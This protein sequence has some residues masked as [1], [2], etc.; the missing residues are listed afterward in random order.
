M[1]KVLVCRKAGSEGRA[2]LKASLCSGLIM[3]VDCV[4]CM[5]QTQ[6][7]QMVDFDVSKE[8]SWR[9]MNTTLV[10][11]DLIS[12]IFEIASNSMSYVAGSLQ[13]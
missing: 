9:S 1:A 10:S 12:S 13:R 6:E 7:G 11:R 8:T 5:L 3:L 4:L 2:V